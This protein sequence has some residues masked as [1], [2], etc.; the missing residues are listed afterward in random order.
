[1]Q[2]LTNETVKTMIEESGEMWEAMRD[3]INSPVLI[4]VDEQ[5]SAFA[6]ELSLPAGEHHPFWR[7]LERELTPEEDAS[8]IA[9]LSRG[10]TYRLSDLMS[11]DVKGSYFRVRAYVFNGRREAEWDIS[12]DHVTVE[13]IDSSPVRAKLHPPVERLSFTLV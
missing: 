1:M 2:P 6:Y 10:T 11:R 12:V 4:Q 8:R 9:F 3:R 13:I 5:P 7:V